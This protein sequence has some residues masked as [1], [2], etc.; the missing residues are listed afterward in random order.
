M[1]QKI[2]SWLNFTQKERLN[3]KRILLFLFL[4]FLNNFNHHFEIKRI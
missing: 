1:Q 4:A 3:K 2:N